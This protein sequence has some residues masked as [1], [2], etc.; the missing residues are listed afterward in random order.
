M[1]TLGSQ[2]WQS[3]QAEMH[4]EYY[5]LAGIHRGRRRIF[6]W[7]RY[8]WISAEVIDLGRR[9]DTSKEPE[10]II[11]DVGAGGRPI[12]TRAEQRILRFF[13]ERD[14]APATD[15]E[16]AAELGM[17]L[18]NIRKNL[19]RAS[20]IVTHSHDPVTYVAASMDPDLLLTP[21][22]KVIIDD[23]KANGPANMHTLA[24][25]TGQYQGTISSTV[26]MNPDLFE[27]KRINTRRRNTNVNEA[28]VSL[29]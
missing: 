27:V 23:I 26:Q 17:R 11:Q 19:K 20:W 6:D 4:Q 14:N 21:K 28:I 25:R 2:G 1:T 18:K 8:R 10:Q 15:E 7:T 13:H 24:K 12:P 3:R 5:C 9:P 22:A 16:I 29:K